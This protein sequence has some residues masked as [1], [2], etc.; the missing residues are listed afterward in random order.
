MGLSKG[1]T[2]NPDGRPKGSKNKSSEAIREMVST[3]I[4]DN[5]EQIQT[6]LNQLQP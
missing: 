2:N 5:W 4:T 6:D 3:L 1:K